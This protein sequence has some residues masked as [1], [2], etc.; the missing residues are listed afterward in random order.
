VSLLSKSDIL[1]P[2]LGVTFSYFVA[3]TDYLFCSL[4]NF[5][6]LFKEKIMYQ[7]LSN[8]LSCFMTSIL[9]CFMQCF[10]GSFRSKFRRNGFTLVELLVVIAII[11][12]LIALLLPA[13]QA[14]REAARRSQCTNNLKQLGIGIHNYHDTYHALP[15]ICNGTYGP[16]PYHKTWW[17][18]LV[19]ILPFIEQNSI[20][21]EYRSKVIGGGDWHIEFYST[22]TDNPTTKNIMTFYCP[23]NGVTSS[24][25]AN[26][27]AG[28]NYR[29]CLG[30]NPSGWDGTGNPVA[31]SCRGGRGPFGNAQQNLNLAA[32]TDGTSNT[33]MFGECCL[34]QGGHPAGTVYT[35]TSKMVKVATYQSATAS[36]IG[37]T[38]S[39][40]AYLSDRTKVLGLAKGA[41]YDTSVITLTS[42]RTIY[43][44]IYVAGCP[45]YATFATTLPP[46]T[47]SVV[48]T[49]TYNVMISA[50][51]YHSGGVNVSL[52]DGSVR[53]VSDTVDSG[54][55]TNKKFDTTDGNVS[56]A[57]PFGIWG[58][59]GSRDGNE[60]TSF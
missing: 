23:S 39:A 18:G 41:E 2:F 27:T 3:K 60:S 54:P 19:G 45:W 28:T 49:G 9:A 37:F 16:T 33:L 11:G 21:E 30:D 29:F 1:L 7:I 10:G 50:T 57:S 14:A 26:H 58:A 24:K 35:A 42:L 43:G 34:V 4:L 17:S 47:P 44:W 6:S 15:A 38:G 40:P 13:V 36:D 53:F 56:G 8:F 59:Y 22:V 51:S 52:V 48:Y 55:A 5:N 25:P 12:V 32:T 46:N 31:T 20:Y